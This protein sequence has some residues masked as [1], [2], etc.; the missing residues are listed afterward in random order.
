MFLGVTVSVQNFNDKEKSF[1]LVIPENPLTDYVQLPE[2]MKNLNYSNLLCGVIRGALEM[3]NSLTTF[4]ISQIHM[5][6]ECHFVQDIL[7]DDNYSEIAVKL[8]KKIFRSID[9]D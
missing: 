3:V 8:K 9:D 4:H 1:S 6:V 5:E 7:K 2:D